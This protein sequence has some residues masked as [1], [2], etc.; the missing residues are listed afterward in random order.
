MDGVLSFGIGFI[1]GVAFVVVFAF[2]RAGWF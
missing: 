2:W 1:A